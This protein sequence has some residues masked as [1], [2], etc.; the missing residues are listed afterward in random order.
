MLQ[1]Q[2]L[3]AVNWEKCFVRRRFV[4]IYVFIIFFSSPA[5]LAVL[6]SAS[7]RSEQSSTC[8]R[9]TDFPCSL[10]LPA[11]LFCFACR[12]SRTITFSPCYATADRN[13]WC[14]CRARVSTLH[15]RDVFFFAQSPTSRKYDST[16]KV[17]ASRTLPRF[18]RKF[19]LCEGETKWRVNKALVRGF[20]LIPLASRQEVR[21]LRQKVHF[22]VLIDFGRSMSRTDCVFRLHHFRDILLSVWPAPRSR[23]R[24]RFENY[25]LEV[26]RSA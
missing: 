16:I 9:P 15:R 1:I 4:A 20:L 10:L 22:V 7:K 21:Y 11:V 12:R 2:L 5:R 8:S 18:R 24:K 19:C 17:N 13:Q 6:G 3:N 23:R 26:I 14:Y 25:S